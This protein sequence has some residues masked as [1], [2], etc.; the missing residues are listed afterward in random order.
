MAGFVFILFYVFMILVGI[1]SHLHSAEKAHTKIKQHIRKCG[2]KDVYIRKHSSN[3]A[4]H[5]FYVQ[6][7]DEVGASYSTIC[8]FT[9]NMLL[10]QESPAYLLTGL[11]AKRPLPKTA[12][13]RNTRPPSR[14]RV[15]KELLM[16]DL[17][18]PFRSERLTAVTQLAELPHIDGHFIQKLGEIAMHDDDPLVQEHATELLNTL[19]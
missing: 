1:S 11:A 12:T 5:M 2:G 16:D 6:F 18:S 19:I 14:R 17:H 15:D 13:P 4:G 3:K 8:M 9:G 10:W 7:S